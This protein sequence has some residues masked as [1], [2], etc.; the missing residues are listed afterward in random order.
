MALTTLKA[1]PPHRLAAEALCHGSRPP[2]PPVSEP[3]ARIGDVR[4]RSR[5]AAVIAIGACGAYQLGLGAYFVG[6]RPPLLPEDL[7]FLG[8]AAGELGA[9]I[10]RFE[11]W[12]D[13]VF[14]VSGGQMAALGLLLIGLALRLAHGRVVHIRD[15]LLLGAAGLLSVAVMSAANFALGSDFRWLLVLP[16][17]VWLVAVTSAVLAEVARAPAGEASHDS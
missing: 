5:R 17:L 14:L 12:L 7:R 9:L 1:A 4:G 16:V 6:F 11:R 15:V 13:L 3:G 8:A 2:G 10:P